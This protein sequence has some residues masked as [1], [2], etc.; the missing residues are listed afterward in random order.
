VNAVLNA[1]PLHYMQAFMLSKWVLNTIIKITHRF[2]WRD[3]TD[4]FSRGHCLVPWNRV[5]LPKQFRL[6]LIDLKL[7]NQALLMKWLWLANQNNQYS[8][9]WN[10]TLASIGYTLPIDPTTTPRH[11]NIF[12]YGGYNETKTN[13]DRHDSKG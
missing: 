9:L 13:F 7:Q 4:T 10:S 6:G 8:S 11:H 12:L 3:T 2:L 5:T 1:M